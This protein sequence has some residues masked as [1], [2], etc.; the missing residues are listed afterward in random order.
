MRLD[1]INTFLPVYLSSN[2]YLFYVL[3]KVTISKILRLQISRTFI[4]VFLLFLY[5]LIILR[6]Q[7]ALSHARSKLSI[8]SHSQKKK[9]EESRSGARL[10]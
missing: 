10:F 1:L 7:T 9:V 4:S 3:P 5:I 8:T 6:F 2:S